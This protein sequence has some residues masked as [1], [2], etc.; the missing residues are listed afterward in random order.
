M[1]GRISEIEVFIKVA[2]TGSF[3]AAAAMLHLSPSAVSKI[4]AR[5]EDRLGLPLAIRSTR[6]LRL[7]AEG[8]DYYA[9]GKQILKE[10][11]AL[12]RGVRE[13]AG[14]V[15][16]TLRVSCNVPFGIHKISPLLPDFLAAYP[17]ISLEFSLSDRPADLIR[18]GIDVAIRTGVM[19]DSTIRARVLVASPR[20][21][22]ASPGYLEARGIPAMPRDL[23][24]HNCLTL[25]FN[26]NY[27]KWPFRIVQDGVASQLELAVRGNLSLDNGEAL[28]RSALDGIGLA[29]LS[30]FHVGADIRSGRLDVV[31]DQFNP[32]DREP[33][34]IIYS[35]QS[36]LSARIRAFVDFVAAR[37]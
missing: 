10:V 29:R 34:S 23:L 3:S 5:I 22:V 20:Y 35:D 18:D 30:E 31:L 1:S 2:E 25:G 28:R 36:H 9:R 26:R 16:G 11:E 15:G 12:E 19:A 21:I 8:E 7:T 27:A 4:V 13:S 32:G 17:G 14:M 33:V 37:V 6:K 24:D